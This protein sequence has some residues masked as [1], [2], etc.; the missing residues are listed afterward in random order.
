MSRRTKSRKCDFFDALPIRGEIDACKMHQLEEKLAPG[1]FIYLNTF[2]K[3]KKVRNTSACRENILK[4]KKYV[5]KKKM[6][7]SLWFYIV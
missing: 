5:S 3:V 2:R 6:M 7:R 4:E 1:K